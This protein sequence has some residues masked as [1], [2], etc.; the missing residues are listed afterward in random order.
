[1]WGD[2]VRSQKW[3]QFTLHLNESLPESEDVVIRSLDLFHTA[4]GTKGLFGFWKGECPGCKPSDLLT[5]LRCLSAPCVTQQIHVL[6]NNHKKHVFQSH[7]H[8]IFLDEVL[9]ACSSWKLESTE[10]SW[11]KNSPL[12]KIIINKKSV[13]SYI[14]AQMR[15]VIS[16]RFSM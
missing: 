6:H 14:L 12:K 1:M 5:Q 2:G 4:T 7:I 3:P 9:S 10:F 11:A 15:S 8:T 13:N 16:D